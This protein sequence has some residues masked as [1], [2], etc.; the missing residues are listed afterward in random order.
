MVRYYYYY[1]SQLQHVQSLATTGTT[2]AAISASLS[3]AYFLLSSSA[4]SHQE[5]QNPHCMGIIETNLMDKIANKPYLNYH[6][7]PT[8]VPTTTKSAVAS[9]TTNRTT[10]ATSSASPNASHSTNWPLGVPRQMRILTIDVP[11]FRNVFDRECYVDMT[12]V[13]N[14]EVLDML[15]FPH[16]DT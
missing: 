7:V 11:Q 5:E 12:M 14:Y 8:V 9:T 2:V 10:D 6:R 1:L 4:S 15:R 16:L 3:A 13:S